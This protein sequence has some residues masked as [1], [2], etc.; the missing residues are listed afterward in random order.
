[1]LSL[2]ER[3]G[4]S[5]QRSISSEAQMLKYVVRMCVCCVCITASENVGEGRLE[6]F[7]KIYRE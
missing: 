3:E 7:K 5:F 6:K 2:R 4:G 1:M